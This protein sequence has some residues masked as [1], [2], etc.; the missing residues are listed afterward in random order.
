MKEVYKEAT[1]KM[2]K[3]L[4]VKSVELPGRACRSIL[5][6]IMVDYYGTPTPIN[7]VGNITS[8]DRLLVFPLGT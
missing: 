7:Q 5:D 3:T 1:T 6:R 2:G 8:P 4:N